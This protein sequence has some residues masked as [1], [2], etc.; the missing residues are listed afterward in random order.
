M[1]GADY[2][3][4]QELEEERS[5]HALEV[6][7]RVMWHQPTSADLLYLAHELGVSEQFNRDLQQRKV[8]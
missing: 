2:R 6:L 5:Q 7:Q 4:L 3:Q 8:A 1:N